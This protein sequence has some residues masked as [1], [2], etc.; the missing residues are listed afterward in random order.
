MNQAI[1]TKLFEED[2]NRREINFGIGD[3]VKVHYRILESGKER[4]QVYEGV[5]ISFKNK[6]NDKTVTIRRVSYDVGVERIF[7]LYSPRIAK[8]ELTRKGDV[9][10]SKLY[11]LRTKSGKEAR[12]KELRG[13]KAIVQAEKRKEKERSTAAKATEEKAETTE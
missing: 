5:V 1:A 9:R 8:F 12:I 11:Y 13:G 7:P 6:S 3:T 4:V 10:R 2:N